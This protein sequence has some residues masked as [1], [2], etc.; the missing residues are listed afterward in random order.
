M[1]NITLRITD[2]YAQIYECPAGSTEHQPVRT[3]GSFCYQ[4]HLLESREFSAAETACRVDGGNIVN[5]K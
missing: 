2:S 3:L 1:N 4:F 5:I